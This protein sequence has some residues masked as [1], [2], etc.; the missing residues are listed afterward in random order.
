MTDRRTDRI[1]MAKTHWLSRVN[2]NSY[3]GR[4]RFVVSCAVTLIELVFFNLFLQS[5]AYGMSLWAVGGTLQVARP[6]FFNLC[7]V[8]IMAIDYFIK[9]LERLCG[10]VLWHGRV[11]WPKAP[12]L[13]RRCS[14]T[15]AVQWAWVR[16]DKVQLFCSHQRAS[17]QQYKLQVYT[18]GWLMQWTLWW[19]NGLSCW[20]H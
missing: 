20:P 4:E 11:A 3:L 16:S 19:S 17:N 18:D 13:R 6:R 8:V 5:R 9:S 15:V 10:G 1:G 12:P 14:N 2:A 7:S